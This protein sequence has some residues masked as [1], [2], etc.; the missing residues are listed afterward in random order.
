M[1]LYGLRN[2]FI[3]FIK[4]VNGFIGLG[5]LVTLHWIINRQ[6]AD[7]NEYFV[8]FLSLISLSTLILIYFFY[9]S[10]QKKENLFVNIILTILRIWAA[11]V[12]LYLIYYC[13]LMTLSQK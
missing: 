10:Y 5:A 9:N 13:T 8:V 11:T 12:S 6:N 7:P 1:L 4:F 3:E 2:K